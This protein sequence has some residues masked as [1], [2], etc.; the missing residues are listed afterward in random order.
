MIGPAV[1]VW[2][3]TRPELITTRNI[4][5]ETKS[6]SGSVAILERGQIRN[7]AFDLDRN[8]IPV[9]LFP[10]I[11]DDPVDISPRASSALRFYSAAL[12][13]APL[14]AFVPRI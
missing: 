4:T 12:R 13:V 7:S 8:G 2:A 14:E 11:Q 3:E 10:I 9:P 1:V 5:M 6:L